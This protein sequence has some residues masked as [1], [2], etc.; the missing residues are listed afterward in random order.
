MDSGHIEA[1]VA[2]YASFPG[3]PSYA[4]R[5]MLGSRSA[6]HPVTTITSL[7]GPI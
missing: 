2:S 6:R 4:S 7:I 3:V 5:K 1:P